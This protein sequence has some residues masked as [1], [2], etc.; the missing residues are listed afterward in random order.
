[1]LYV[2]GDQNTS[3]F[4]FLKFLLRF[5][6]TCCNMVTHTIS[7]PRAVITTFSDRLRDATRVTFG[8]PTTLTLTY[9]EAIPLVFPRVM[10][11][12]CSI[13]A[14]HMYAIMAHK[15]PADFKF[16][17][18]RTVTSTCSNIFEN[19][20]NKGQT[21]DTIWQWG[22]EMWATETE[23]GTEEPETRTI[24]TFSSIHMFRQQEATYMTELWS[25][26]HSR[27]Y[28]LLYAEGMEKWY[29][30]MYSGQC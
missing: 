25:E 28:C 29:I 8:T 9:P 1:M 14:R 20:W 22:M 26:K 10:R 12:N 11:Y 5:A 3:N 24:K 18:Q 16:Q 19:S 7:V 6:F 21:G 23:E 17:L 13:P 15:H 30:S 4:F 2:T 27:R